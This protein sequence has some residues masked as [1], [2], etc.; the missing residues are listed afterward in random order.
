MVEQYFLEQTCAALRLRTATLSRYL[1]NNE[2]EDVCQ[3]DI[4]MFEESLLASKRLILGLGHV[5][6]VTEYAMLSPLESTRFT[7]IL[8]ASEMRAAK[9]KRT[10]NHPR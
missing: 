2:K 7:R 8:L 1:P 9:L 5:Q 3:N 10:L 6:K 4:Q